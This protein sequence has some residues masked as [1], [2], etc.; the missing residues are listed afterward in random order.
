MMLVFMRKILRTL[1]KN[2]EKCQIT[3]F[4]EA[5]QDPSYESQ[6]AKTIR[7]TYSMH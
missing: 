7:F 6:Q 2:A 4:L 5:L 3:L 1:K